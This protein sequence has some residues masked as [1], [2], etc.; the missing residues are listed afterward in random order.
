MH[1]GDIHGAVADCSYRSAPILENRLT[2]IGGTE[3]V[4]NQEAG[5]SPGK[6]YG[7]D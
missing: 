3:L 2:S 1:G 7:A 5:F 6:R 4:G